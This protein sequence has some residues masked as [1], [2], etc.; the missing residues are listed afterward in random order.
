MLK[1]LQE[2]LNERLLDAVEVGD[3]K[4]AKE[5]IQRG[6][7]VQVKGDYCIC[8]AVSN[9]YSKLTEILINSGADVSVYGNYPIRDAIVKEHDGTL[10]IICKTAIL[11][12]QVLQDALRM[13]VAFNKPKSL[14]VI[15]EYCE[16]TDEMFEK[17]VEQ[18]IS[19]RE[20][21]ISQILIKNA[22][23]DGAAKAL[24]IAKRC[25]AKMEFI[26]SIVNLA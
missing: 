2:R 23:S 25:G 14:K 8:S 10:G 3:Y 19:A 21:E 12:E 26:Q 16:L 1:K 17:Y 18:S 6:A 9:G 20:Q 11:D 7:N 5:L 13:A 24:E 22:K 15:L 4:G